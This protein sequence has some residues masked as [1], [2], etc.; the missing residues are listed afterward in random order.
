MTELV[1]HGRDI[2]AARDAVE[3]ARQA[4][5]RGGSPNAVVKAERALANAHLRYQE[6]RAGVVHDPRG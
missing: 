2:E 4:Y 3:R 5:S 6:C 1:K